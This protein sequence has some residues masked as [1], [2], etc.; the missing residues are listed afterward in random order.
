MT[1]P[2][3][4]AAFT[5]RLAEASD[6]GALVNIETSCFEQDRM[7]KRSFKRWIKAAHGILIIA[8][9][10]SQPVGYGLVWCHKGTRLARLYSLAVLEE[11]R[12]T[13][14]ATQLLHSLE[15]AAVDRHCLYMRLEVAENNY[16]AIRLYESLGYRVFGQHPEYY[17][18]ATNALRMQKTIRQY[19]GENAAHIT[20]WYQQSTDFTCGPAALM[21][22]MASL[23]QGIALGEELELDLWREATTIFMTSGHGGCHPVGLALAAQRRG[24]EAQVFLNTSEPLFLNGVR[25]AHKKYIMEVVHRQFLETAQ[26]SGLKVIYEELTQEELERAM[27]DGWL[28][29]VLISTFR[30][31]DKKT[32]HW[33]TVTGVD[34]VCFYLHDPD[35]DEGDL[36]AV[37]RQH[38]PILRE[39]F[40]KMS[41]FGSQRLRAAVAIRREAAP[42]ADRQ[43]EAGHSIERG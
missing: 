29:L 13:G 24:F 7:S 5:F 16:P 20:P 25:S 1:T 11:M 39:D 26:H 17:E 31:D 42:P 27:A 10:E 38:L 19:S 3:A 15:A 18:D 36:L 37:D 34:D 9:A 40:N 30:M 32:P 22:A 28:V 6:L 35:C 23:Q 8:Q 43:I 12:G 4:G 21:M 33:V 2:L 41:A 14:L